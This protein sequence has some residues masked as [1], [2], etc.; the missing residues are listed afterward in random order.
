MGAHRTTLATLRRVVHLTQQELADRLGCSQPLIARL[1]RRP[2]PK[3]T[4]RSVSAYVAALGGTC[5][6]LIELDGQ[7]F[8]IDL[9]PEGTAALERGIPSSRS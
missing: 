6:L 9:E 4:I 5:R 8:E 2:L 7:Q 1:E 3:A